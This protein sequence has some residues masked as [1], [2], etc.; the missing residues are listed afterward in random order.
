MPTAAGNADYGHVI[1]QPVLCLNGAVVLGCV[2][3]QGESLGETLGP[4]AVSETRW[5]GCSLLLLPCFSFQQLNAVPCIVLADLTRAEP[6][7][8]CRSCLR[9]TRLVVAPAVYSRLFRSSARS[10]GIPIAADPALMTRLTLLPV[11][12]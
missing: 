6:I 4:N 8:D 10:R 9:P 11:L 5:V 1:C 2:S 7:A 12:P 3:G